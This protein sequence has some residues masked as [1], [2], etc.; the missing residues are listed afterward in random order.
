MTIDLLDS[1]IANGSLH[2]TGTREAS[3]S[4]EILK[5]DGQLYTTGGDVSTVV[6]VKR[7]TA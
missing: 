7:I 5:S 2:D 1:S 4:V 3:T 6:F